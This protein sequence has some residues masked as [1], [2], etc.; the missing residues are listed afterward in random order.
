MPVRRETQCCYKNIMTGEPDSRAE[1][2][3]GFP[4]HDFAIS[5]AF[6]GGMPL[7]YCPELC[8]AI[9]KDQ[10]ELLASW[11]PN[12]RESPMRYACVSFFLVLV[13]VTGDAH[14]RRETAVHEPETPH[15]EF[16]TEYI[17][18]LGAIQNV[19]EKGERELKEDPGPAS[20]IHS[21]TLFQLELGFEI[22]TLE[23]MRLNAPY[24]TLIPNITG[25]YEHKIALW[26]RISEISGALVGT[27]KPGVDYA[28]LAAE[29]PEI[30][31]KL[32]YI[33][34]ALF[35]GSA[36]VAASLI[37]MKPDSKNHANHLIITK[38]DKLTLIDRLENRFG[39]KLN[40]NDQNY[41]ISTAQMLRSFLKDHKGSDEP[42]D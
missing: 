9:D 30:R 26:K 29:M 33:D 35:E 5:Q 38:A 7:V 42:W 18:E 3:L 8:R 21:S 13:S 15:L 34:Q 1:L 19:R 36:L 37:D 2:E 28:K 23:D 22:A 32:D 24:D 40:L 11:P 10:D 4:S 25:F 16:V 12:N 20:A 41:T 39:D 17:R 27:P 31:A 14:Q 6:L